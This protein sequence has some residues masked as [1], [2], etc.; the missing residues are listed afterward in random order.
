MTRRVLLPLLVLAAGL[1]ACA[2]PIPD[3]VVEAK[4]PTEHYKATAQARPEEIRLVVHAQGLSTTQAAALA[5]FADDWSNAEGGQITLWSPV[6][7]PDAQAAFRTGEG[8]RTFLISRGVPADRIAVQ[9]YDAQGDVQAS[10]RVGYMRYEAIIPACGQ[11][12]QNVAH[13]RSNDVQQNFGCAVTANLAAQIANPADL[14]RPR[15][16]GPVDSQRRM[17]VLDKY[18]KGE[19]VSSAKDAQAQGVISDAIK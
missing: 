16:M 12:W 14:V 10:L 18:R 6:G 13:S 17:T 1:S 11:A 2:T 3:R 19:V 9:G 7:G 5:Q 8:A 15:D 4:T